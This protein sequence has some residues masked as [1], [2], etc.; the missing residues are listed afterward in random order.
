MIGIA[1]IVI[2]SSPEYIVAKPTRNTHTGELALHCYDW[3]DFSHSLGCKTIP[4]ILIYHVFRVDASHPGVVYLKEYSNGSET[5]VN[6][7]KSPTAVESLFFPSVILPKGLSLE[8]QWYLNEKIRTLCHS[9]LSCYIT[10]PKPSQAKVQEKNCN[11]VIINNLESSP[12]TS[13]VYKYH[14]SAITLGLERPLWCICSNPGH[15]EKICPN[16]T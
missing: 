4:G 11:S 3:V 14:T 16:K 2:E 15:K 9:N 6:I 13:F 7:L 5:A 1:H 10:C 8:G 12:A